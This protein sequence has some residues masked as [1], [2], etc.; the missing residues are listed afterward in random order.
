MTASR[1]WFIALGLLATCACATRDR[2]AWEGQ[3]ANQLK[4]ARGAPLSV[5]PL[6][7]GELWNYPQ[8]ETF[9]IRK[10]KVDSRHRDPRGQERV[11]QF[12]WNRSDLGRKVEVP[13]PDPRF[14]ELRFIDR[15][16][17]VVFDAESGTVTR[18]VEVPHGS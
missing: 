2:H 12:W 17:V 8:G 18:V 10:G 16:C 1:F 11:I 3:S 15:A 13:S 7:D 9:Q 14:H 4:S 6:I 5:V